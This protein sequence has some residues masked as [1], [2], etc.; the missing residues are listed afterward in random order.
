MEG[1]K[2]VTKDLYMVWY[3]VVRSTVLYAHFFNRISTCRFLSSARPAYRASDMRMARPAF[4]ARTGE[5]T[6]QGSIEKQVQRKESMP[7]S[8][9]RYSF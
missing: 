7:M 1:N 2:S 4:L 3:S 5:F 9:G 8:P 6:R